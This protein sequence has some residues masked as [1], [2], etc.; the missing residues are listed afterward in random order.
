MALR[1][2]LG[3]GSIAFS[4][5]M[6]FRPTQAA[7]VMAMDEEK[8]QQIAARDFGCGIE[9]LVGQNPRAAIVSRI[10]YDLDDMAALAPNRPFASVFAALV[11]L[12]GVAAFITND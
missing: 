5:W 10:R 2:L 1:Y 9:I 11:A 7:A 4:L 8:I 12:L 6:M 3:A